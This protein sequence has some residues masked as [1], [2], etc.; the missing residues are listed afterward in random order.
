M[1][2][3]FLSDHPQGVALRVKAVPG[4]KRPGIGAPIGDRLKVK[5]SAP[6]EDGKANAAICALVAKAL[7]LKPSQVT[8][9]SGP[10]DPSKVLLVEGLPKAEISR[11][12]NPPER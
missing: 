11:L 3:P 12:L 10:T 8:L 6:P 2:A 9:I 1:S 7:G 4:A 5:V